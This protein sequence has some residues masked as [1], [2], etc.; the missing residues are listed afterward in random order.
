VRVGLLHGVQEEF[1]HFFFFSFLY[2][3]FFSFLYFFSF[4]LFFLESKLVLKSSHSHAHVPSPATHTPMST[5]SDAPKT[6]RL[7]I[8]LAIQHSH[9]WFIDLSTKLKRDFELDHGGVSESEQTAV[10]LRL[11]AIQ[12]ALTANFTHQYGP[13][14]LSDAMHLMG[15]I[16][17]DHSGLVQ[18][19][20][21]HAE[22]G[23]F[24]KNDKHWPKS[25]S[26]KNA[27]RAKHD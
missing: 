19:L 12:S 1:Q 18:M 21:N 6:M 27:K 13:I 10:L 3:F 8:D 5:P 16:L 15:V 17:P 4:R 20:K 25:E 7:A 2:F 23:T 22:A 11:L 14:T 9:D 26:E 24:H